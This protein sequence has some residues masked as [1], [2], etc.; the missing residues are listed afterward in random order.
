MRL[1]SSLHAT[2]AKLHGGMR[3]E[4]LATTATGPEQG[5]EFKKAYAE[6]ASATALANVM[7]QEHGAGS[8]QFA[9][10]DVASMRLFHRVKK[11]QGLR[12]PRGR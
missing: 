4:P 5:N 9:S 8:P 1:W 7:L 2:F 11:M 3:D 6:Y 12:K 10:A